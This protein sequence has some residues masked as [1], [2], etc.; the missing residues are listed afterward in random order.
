VVRSRDRDTPRISRRVPSVQP[1][2]ER[3]PAARPRAGLLTRRK[4]VRSEP[5]S[6][7]PHPGRAA[8]TEGVPRDLGYACRRAAAPRTADRGRRH[9]WRCEFAHWLRR[10]RKGRRVEPEAPPRCGSRDALRHR[11]PKLR[12]GCR[13]DFPRN[14][15]TRPSLEAASSVPSLAP[16]W[17]EKRQ[18]GCFLPQSVPYP[19]PITRSG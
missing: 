14:H 2:H 9:P 3:K 19:A 17:R 1:I 11:R 6:P 4:S 18:F 7:Q 16:R 13:C 10:E 12:G 8:G 15:P 5:R